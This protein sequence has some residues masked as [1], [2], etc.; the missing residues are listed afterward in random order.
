[1]GAGIREEHPSKKLGT[2]TQI[3]TERK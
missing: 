3:P 2:K 1:M